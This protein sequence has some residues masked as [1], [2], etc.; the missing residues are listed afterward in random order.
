MKPIP[1]QTKGRGFFGR[2]WA[3]LT[4]VR[5]WELA[6]NYYHELPCGR[7]VVI[8]K[9]FVFD[10][11]SI[12]KPLWFILSPVGLLLIGGLIHD[13][14]YRYSYLWIKN[15]DGNIEKWVYATDRISYDLLFL[16]VNLQVNGMILVDHLASFL[17]AMFGWIAWN[18]NR[19]L[20]A[21]DIVP[22]IPESH[23]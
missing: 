9:G 3:L 19:K 10:G 17:L 14:A 15:K 20:N 8:P 4:V 18:K 6:E 7:V 16:D 22:S 1:I 2:V 11:A 21:P 13:F 5:Q 12:P 23:A